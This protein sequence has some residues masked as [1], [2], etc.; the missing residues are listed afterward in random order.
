M[1]ILLGKLK[2]KSALITC[3]FISFSLLV[4][5]ANAT[6][7]QC[8]SAIISNQTLS[9]EVDEWDEWDAF[10]D[11][12]NLVHYL[13]GVSFY[14]GHPK[15]Q[16]SLVPDNENAHQK[17]LFWTFKHEEKI[18]LVCNYSNTS[19]QLIHKLPQSIKK[20]IVNFADKY[21]NTIVNIRCI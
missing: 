6:N 16:A 17:T 19:I 4:K 15:K 10:I 8:P 5:T 21:S 1:K 2:M 7:Y 13:N 14:S 12:N 20:C 9:K 18:Y 11:K 3:F